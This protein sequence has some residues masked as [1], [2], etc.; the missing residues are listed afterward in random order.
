GV[1]V[2][3]ATMRARKPGAKRSTWDS[4]RSVM[5]AVEACGTW[6]YAQAVCWPAGA[7]VESNRLGCATSTNGRALGGRDL[8]E[9]S[10]H[11]DRAGAGA[12]GCLPR[13]RRAQGPIDFE[14]AGTITVSL[15]L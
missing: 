4:M 9:R 6:Q 1:I 13:D 2:W 10:A 7:R 15:Q 14:N 5:S 3:R 8:V 12:L 11:V